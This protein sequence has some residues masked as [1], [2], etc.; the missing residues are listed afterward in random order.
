[1]SFVS[2]SLGHP[3]QLALVVTIKRNKLGRNDVI[4]PLYCVF[5]THDI[6]PTY[7]VHFFTTMGWH[8]FIKLKWNSGARSDRFSI[9]DSVFREMPLPYPSLGR[10]EENRRAVRHNK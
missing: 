2:K 10:A 6:D 8:K 3:D 7:L 9:K 5:R 1:M 4:F